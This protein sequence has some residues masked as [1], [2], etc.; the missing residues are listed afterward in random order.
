MVY[1]ESCTTKGFPTRTP[2]PIECTNLSKWLVVCESLVYSVFP[3]ASYHFPSQSCPLCLLGVT[4][5]SA[6]SLL[7]QRSPS[8]AQDRLLSSIN[9]GQ[10]VPKAGSSTSEDWVG[11]QRFLVKK[12]THLK[13][14]LPETGGDAFIVSY[15][16]PRNYRIESM[17]LRWCRCPLR[18]WG[19]Y[20]NLPRR[21]SWWPL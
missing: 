12:R 13:S 2:K 6:C 8:R 1:W 21:G 3:F 17:R 18:W 15:V 16:S 20:R 19:L 11:P 10:P 9:A 14:E 5:C 4:L 7:Q